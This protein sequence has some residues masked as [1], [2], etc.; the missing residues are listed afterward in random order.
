MIMQTNEKLFPAI[1]DEGC[2]M[3]SYMFIASR[4]RKL[5]WSPEQVNLAYLGWLNQ[6]FIQ[7]NCRVLQ[8]DKVMESLGLE[9]DG[10]IR[11]EN[12]VAYRPSQFEAV[13]ERWHNSRTGHTHFVVGSPWRWDSLGQ[14]VTV[15]DGVCN[16]LTI[17]RFVEPIWSEIGSKE[18]VV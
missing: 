13:I 2:L 16:R 6:K 18:I 10:W 15:R 14:S 4:L 11:H 17:I 5:T 9:L 7:S 8:P 1:R 3:L 12:N